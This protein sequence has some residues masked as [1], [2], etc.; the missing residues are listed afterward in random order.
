MDHALIQ[1][2]SSVLTSTLAPQARD[3]R[4]LMDREGDVSIY[5]APFE[6]INNH[7]KIALVGITPGPTQMVNACLAARAVLASGGGE[8]E[9]VRA[10]KSEGAF[11]GEPLR[12]NLVRQL[13]H[14]KIDQWLGLGDADQLFGNAR[15]LIQTTSLLRFPV[16]VGEKPYAGT[17]DMTRNPMLRRYLKDYFVRELAALPDAL[18]VSLGPTVQRALQW[19]V[20]QGYVPA[21]RVA[22]G[23]L[24]PSGNCTYRINYLIGDRS[25]PIP[26]ATNVTS[27]DQGRHAFMTHH[28][29]AE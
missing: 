27:Y 14:W 7:A 6:Y 9:A 2:F 22:L 5:Y 15:H 11:S 16:F 17:P 12:S 21:D 23:M 4:L 10:G 25:K 19:L 26:H 13:R 18:F 24:H 8:E 3:E 20:D 29:V 28:V 1:R